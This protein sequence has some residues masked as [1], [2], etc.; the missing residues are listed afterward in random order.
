MVLKEK[1]EQNLSLNYLVFFFLFY[2]NAFVDSLIASVH[3][4][5]LSNSTVDYCGHTDHF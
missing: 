3:K 2:L 4:L 5:Y 1:S